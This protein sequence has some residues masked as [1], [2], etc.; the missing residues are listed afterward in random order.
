MPEPLPPAAPV[1]DDPALLR[2]LVR[3]AERSDALW[4][5]TPYWRSYCARISRRLEKTGLARFRA[6]QRLLKG[7]AAGGVTRPDEPAA[8]WK[9]AVWRGLQRLPGVRN[10][11][12]EYERV[13]RAE[14]VHHT[15]TR[16]LHAGLAMDEIAGAFPAVRPPAGLANGG[17]DDAFAWRGHTLVPGW[18]MHLARIADFYTRVAPDSVTAI[19][20]I[21][22]G[23]GLSSLA[24]LALNPGLKV[25]ANV[26]IVPVLYLST[27]FLK[28]IDAVEVA[29][30]RA[31]REAPRIAPAAGERVRI[32][33]LA[34]WQLPRLEGAFDYF[35]NAFSFQEMEPEVCRNYAGHIHR[36]VRSGVLLH[37][38]IPGHE[39]G[40]GGQREPV[41]LAFLESLFGDAFPHARRIDGLWPRLYGAD[42]ALT[43]LM[44]RAAPRA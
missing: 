13:L 34:P 37:G 35:F 15:R 41:T 10:I 36:L 40:A 5:A 11:V 8:A 17:A 19:V 21:G 25:I 42:P 12:A 16:V 31:L 26:D 1:A 18:V 28:S 30:Y 32:Y 44:T 20:E 2:L 23:L 24:H 39:R 6:D 9:R 7:F 14:H 38:S 22:P 27:Q 43:R 29:D 33:Q 3:D 4:T